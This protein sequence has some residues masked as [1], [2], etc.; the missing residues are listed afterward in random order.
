MPACFGDG[1]FTLRHDT[2]CLILWSLRWRRCGEEVLPTAALQP[3]VLYRSSSSGL[4]W[5]KSIRAGSDL[6]PEPPAGQRGKREQNLRH[7][8][9]DYL[10]VQTTTCL[11]WTSDEPTLVGTRAAGT[12]GMVG[13]ARTRI[14]NES[15]STTS[16]KNHGFKDLHSK[17]S[18]Q[19]TFHPIT[20]AHPSS[21]SYCIK[22]SENMKTSLCV[23]RYWFIHWFTK[24]WK[25]CLWSWQDEYKCPLH[26]KPHEIFFFFF[27]L[28]T[29]GYLE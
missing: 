19:V 1:L 3:R 28:E 29:D 14:Q 8:Q 6:N 24:Y 5:P 26:E 27:V 12:G 22:S 13:L 25:I 21:S 4:D 20:G 11:K 15:T 10:Q 18:G 23:A 7:E 2:N 16:L 9:G 17:S